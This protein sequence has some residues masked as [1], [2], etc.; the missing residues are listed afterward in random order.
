MSA[1]FDCLPCLYAGSVAHS[2]AAAA[3]CG[4]WRYIMRYEFF[5]FWNIVTHHKPVYDLKE[6]ALT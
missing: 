5:V 4:L 2:S 1:G 6:A 3:V